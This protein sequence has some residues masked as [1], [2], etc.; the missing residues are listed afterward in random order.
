MPY[1]F[2]GKACKAYI[3][4]V[5]EALSAAGD[6]HS[7]D[8]FSAC[9]SDVVPLPSLPIRNNQKPPYELDNASNGGHATGVGNQTN[10]VVDRDLYNEIL[11]KI[12]ADDTNTANELYK[13]ISRIEQICASNYNLPKTLP[14]YQSVLDSVKNS[15]EEFRSLTIEVKNNIDSFVEE[16]IN[17]SS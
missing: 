3:E 10:I 8:P 4:A 12:S 2:V 11:N 16:I 5:S 14:N 17:I 15:L 6:E 7:K 13:V 1:G 9:N